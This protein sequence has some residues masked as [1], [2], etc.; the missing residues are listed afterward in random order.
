MAA[1][2]GCGGDGGNSFSCLS[3]SGTSQL[4]IDTTTNAPG[5]PNCGSGTRVDTCPHAGADGGCVH[6][7]AAGGTSLKQTIWYYSG[8]ASLTS[9]EMSDC[10]DNGGTWIAP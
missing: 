10:T 2:A 8:T 6:S 4:C 5:T 7:F 3:G 1:A 9:Q